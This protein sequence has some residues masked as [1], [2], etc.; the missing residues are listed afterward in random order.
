[1]AKHLGLVTGKTEVTVTHRDD[2]ETDPR[3]LA[4]AVVAVLRAG[5]E[6]SRRNPLIESDAD[7]VFT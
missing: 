1:M 4:M 3:R 7:A 6:A 2:A 5:E